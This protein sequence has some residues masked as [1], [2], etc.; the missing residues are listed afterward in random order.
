MT[1]CHLYIMLTPVNTLSPIPA[2]VF[3]GFAYSILLLIW[4]CIGRIVHESK[5]GTA[6]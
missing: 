2:L 3:L 1:L 6:L 4:S 5:R